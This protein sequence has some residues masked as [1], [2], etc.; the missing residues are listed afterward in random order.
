MYNF[1]GAQKKILRQ[2]GLIPHA[3]PHQEILKRYRVIKVYR[4]RVD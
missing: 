3:P 1:L 2:L 4:T